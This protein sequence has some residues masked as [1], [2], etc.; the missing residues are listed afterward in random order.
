VGAHDEMNLV[1]RAIDLLDQPLQINRSAGSS[2]GDDKFHRK[3]YPEFE[4]NPVSEQ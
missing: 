1:R 3:N 2:R 4:F